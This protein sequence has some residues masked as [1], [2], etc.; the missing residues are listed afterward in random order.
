MLIFLS[1]L[2]CDIHT[3]GSPFAVL[4]IIFFLSSTCTSLTVAT[5]VL[6]FSYFFLPKLSSPSSDID[7]DN[8]TAEWRRRSGTVD[9][10]YRTGIFVARSY[11][12]VRMFFYRNKYTMAFSP[13][14][15]LPSLATGSL[16]ASVLG[17]A[18]QHY[19]SGYFIKKGMTLG[20]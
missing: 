19:W 1:G 13:R 12:V 20:R 9:R 5:D 16:P 2:A 10:P 15:T 7:S 18:P 6:P 14:T 11:T 4:S 8:N 17:L 3:S